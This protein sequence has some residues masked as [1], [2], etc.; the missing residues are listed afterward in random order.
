MITLGDGCGSG[1]TSAKP[2]AG[3]R[4]AGGGGIRSLPACGLA[5][6]PQI[7]PRGSK[8]PCQGVRVCEDDRGIRFVPYSQSRLLKMKYRLVHTAAISRI[9]NG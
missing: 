3:S 8:R 7:L 2:Q 9:A 5:H 4:T 1:S 6:S